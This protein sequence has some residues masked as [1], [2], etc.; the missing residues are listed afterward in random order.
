MGTILYKRNAHAASGVIP[1]VVAIY[2]EGGNKYSA[3]AYAGYGPINVYFNQENLPAVGITP[4]GNKVPDIFELMQNY[5]NPFNPNTT[6]RFKI[7]SS[8]YVI[9]KVYDVLGREAATLVNENLKAG[10]Y[11]VNFNAANLTSGVYFYKLSAGCDLR[12]KED[13]GCKIKIRFNLILKAG[14]FTS[15]FFLYA[16]VKI[17]WVYFLN[18]FDEYFK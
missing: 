15:G 14:S 1:P 9:L 3:F 5:P 13:D 16:N 4:I 17:I 11:S 12:C 6:I 7:P 10:E 18:N 2:K 8:K